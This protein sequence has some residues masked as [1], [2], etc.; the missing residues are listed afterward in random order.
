MYEIKKFKHSLP[1]KSNPLKYE[2]KLFG[3]LDVP[4]N[5][6]TF[7]EKTNRLSVFTSIS[8]Y[9]GTYSLLITGTTFM[10]NK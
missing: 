4:E 3:N 7:N 5:L 1:E 6:A 9:Q 2:I 10:Y 8:K